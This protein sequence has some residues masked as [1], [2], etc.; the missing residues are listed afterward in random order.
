MS[1]IRVRIAPSPTGVPHIGNSRTALFNYLFARANGG[2]FIV[3]I[4]DTDQARL[5]PGSMEKILEILAFLGL[6]YDEGPGKEGKFGPYLQSARKDIYQKYADE[7][8]SK[9]WAYEE[10]GAIRF[11]PPSGKKEKSLANTV[12]WDDLIHSKISFEIGLIEPFIIL[13]SD[14]FPTYHLASVVDDHLM[15]ISHVLRGD[16]WISSTPKHLLIYEAFNWEPPLFGHLPLILG[17][18]KSKLS[19]RHGAMSILEYRDQG[20]LKEALINFMTLLGWNP[21]TEDEIFSLEDLIKQFKLEDINKN[22]PVFDSKK[23]DWFNGKYIRNLDNQELA[24]RLKPFIPQEFARDKVLKVLPLVK[25]RMEKLTD[26][27][28]LTTFLF[29]DKIER[30]WKVENGKLKVGNGEW[31]KEVAKKI[32]DKFIALLSEDSNWKAAIFEKEGRDLAE[33]LGLK[34]GEVFMILRVAL[35]GKKVT[36]PLFESLE[37]LGKK[38]VLER[39][40]KSK[41]SLN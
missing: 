40:E 33:K 15:E 24:A 25:E 7:L 31:E 19:K 37:I 39:L 8:V 26:F 20:Y 41:H 1:T 35:A 30:E 34:V 38:T 18:D 27:V 11:N 29:T 2:S 23:L 10:D 21:K 36:P 4:E 6:D 32:I 12:E 17:P 3:R 13:K 14:G 22:N 5:V 28:S 16:E 9:G